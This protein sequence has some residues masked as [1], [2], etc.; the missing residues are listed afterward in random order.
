MLK[1]LCFCSCFAHNANMQHASIVSVV[2]DGKPENHLFSGLISHLQFQRFF[3]GP[4][5]APHPLLVKESGLMTD[6]AEGCVL[7]AL[8][9]M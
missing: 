4:L 5:F 7:S 9:D 8:A 3:Y 6:R 1:Q 2:H